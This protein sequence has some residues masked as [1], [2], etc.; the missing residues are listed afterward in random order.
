MK[1]KLFKLTITVL[2]FFIITVFLPAFSLYEEGY[3]NS[4]DESDENDENEKSQLLKNELTD[5]VEEFEVAK[6]Q[7]GVVEDGEVAFT[8]SAGNVSG[9][10]FNSYTNRSIFEPL[11]MEWLNLMK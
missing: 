6:V 7:V 1:S 9:M 10:D 5:F 11:E 2:S 8:G 3:S 4:S